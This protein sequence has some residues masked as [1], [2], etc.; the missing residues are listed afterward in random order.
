MFPIFLIGKCCA[1]HDV[2]CSFLKAHDHA[3]DTLLSVSRSSQQINVVSLPPETRRIVVR[4]L[5]CDPG[6]R[7][8][9]EACASC[10]HPLADEGRLAEPGWCREE[11]EGAFS[12]SIEQRKQVGAVEEKGMQTWRRQFGEE[13]RECSNGRGVSGVLRVRDGWSGLGQGRFLIWL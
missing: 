13:E 10:C 4:S 7:W 11:R 9:I 2:L 1:Y 3:V 8:K 12:S 5:Q 6:N